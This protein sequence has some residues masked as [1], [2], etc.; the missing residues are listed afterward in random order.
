MDER[1]WWPRAV[2]ECGSRGPTRVV[3]P[4]A[5]ERGVRGHG[6]VRGVARIAR[7]ALAALGAG[8]GDE[9]VHGPGPLRRIGQDRRQ[10]L[11][12]PRL[13]TRMAEGE[14]RARGEAGERRPQ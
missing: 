8:G 6:A 14:L 4:W 10:R 11:A 12:V 3:A 5:G 2:S 7:A 9:R 13:V 1:V